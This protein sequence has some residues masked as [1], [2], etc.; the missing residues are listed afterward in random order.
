MAGGGTKDRI[1]SKS[2]NIERL[3]QILQK[4]DITIVSLQ[5]GDDAKVVKKYREKYHLDFID[6]E[7]IQATKDMNTWLDQVDACDCVLSIANTTIHGAGGLKP[8]LLIG[9]KIRLEMVK[10]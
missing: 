2:V 1:E 6:D 4:F 8:T 5:Y 10:R 9:T 3:L 7:S